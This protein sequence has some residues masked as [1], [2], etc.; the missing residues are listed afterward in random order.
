MKL[1]K[2]G[3]VL[4]ALLLPLSS[5]A[6]SPLIPAGSEL[7][8]ADIADLAVAAPV[9]A[10]VRVTQAI[11]LK[12]KDSGA[13]PGRA[14]FYVEADVVSLIRGGQDVPASIRY[15]ADL[16][17]DAG[18]KT[19]KL[20]KK[21]ELL[22]LAAPVAGRPG[23][24]QLV[25]RDAQLAWTPALADRIRT[26][27]KEASAADAPPRIIGIGK[28]FHVVGSLPG[29]SETQLFLLA[30]D[31]RPISLNILRRPGEQPRWA[32][33][34]GEIVDEAAA[35]P[36]PDTLLWYRLACGLPR[37]LPALSFGDADAVSADAIRAD[38]RLVL[39]RL[40]PCVRT[41]VR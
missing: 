1:S 39:D 4:A 21:A 28:A 17:R 16:P 32:V 37:V 41:R 11:E 34:L 27:L 25:A 33:A 36:A 35:A 18:G 14:R 30:A 12:D 7:T 31:G 20:R 5:H 23:E 29:E 9:A 3:I 13:P 24:L 8:Y 19:P 2:L 38:Y 26:I 40:G 6:E 22:I 10:H 15:L